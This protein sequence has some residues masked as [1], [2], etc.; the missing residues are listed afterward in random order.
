MSDQ[1]LSQQHCDILSLLCR[2]GGLSHHGIVHAAKAV[3]LY[4]SPSGLRTR[5]NEL[6]KA[7]LVKDSGKREETPS[8]RK[9]IIWELA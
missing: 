6:V 8:G 4:T 1:R 5:T 3:Q 9:A 7:G 2:F